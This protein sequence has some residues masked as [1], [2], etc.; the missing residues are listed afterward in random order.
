[1]FAPPT[2]SNVYAPTPA[3]VKRNGTKAHASF[4]GA[5]ALNAA[6]KGSGV[7][8]VAVIKKNSV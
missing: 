5:T 6:Q 2:K 8:S 4:A 3:V 7:P 1:M